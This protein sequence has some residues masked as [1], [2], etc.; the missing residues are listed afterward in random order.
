MSRNLR[1]S[2]FNKLLFRIHYKALSSKHHLHSKQ[3]ENKLLRA[4]NVEYFK[5]LTPN[6]KL[7]SDTNLKFTIIKKS[8]LRITIKYMNIFL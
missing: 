8:Y 4:N 3:I 7:Q 2:K 1:T 6:T 5:N